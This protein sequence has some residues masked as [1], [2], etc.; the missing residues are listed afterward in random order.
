LLQLRGDW[1]H[2][3]NTIVTNKRKALSIEGKVKVIEQRENGKKK[4]LI[5]DGNLVL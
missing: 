5:C 3:N 2:D 4:K 1:Y